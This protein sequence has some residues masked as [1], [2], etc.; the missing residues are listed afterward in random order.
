MKK[1]STESSPD[2]IISELHRIREEIVDSFGG[3]LRRLTDDARRR[4]EASGQ[5]IWRRAEASNLRMQLTGD[6]GQRQ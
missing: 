5:R 6:R 4:Q 3:D 2:T 1:P